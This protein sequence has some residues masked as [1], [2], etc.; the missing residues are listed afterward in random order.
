MKS[1][2]IRFLSV[3]LISLSLLYNSCT[4]VGF[5]VGAIVDSGRP[6]SENKILKPDDFKTIEY[7]QEITI[8]L[9]DNTS[10]V[11]R[12]KE[13]TEEDLILEGT[14]IFWDIEKKVGE[15]FDITIN[16]DEIRSVEI[17][18]GGKYAKW[19]GLGIGFAL[20]LVAIVALFMLQDFFGAR[21]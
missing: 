11:G 21:T 16:L 2:N 7:L 14:K 12:F 5:G 6:D 4:L 8:Y 15:R 9:K 13:I 1:K 10:K 17:K 18:A 19:F 3:L 20:D